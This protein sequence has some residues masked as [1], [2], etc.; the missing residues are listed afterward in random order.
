M[1]PASAEDESGSVWGLFLVDIPSA[2]KA[3]RVD[4]HGKRLEVGH[5]MKIVLAR[6]VINFLYI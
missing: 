6:S 4:A 5:G 2:G 1:E 3:P